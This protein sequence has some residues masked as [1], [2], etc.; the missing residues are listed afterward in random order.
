MSDSLGYS[1][2]PGRGPWTRLVP[3]GAFLLVTAVC[4]LLNTTEMTIHWPLSSKK[5][6]PKGGPLFPSTRLLRSTESRDVLLT[7]ARE[8]LLYWWHIQH[9]QR[10]RHAPSDPA[11]RPLEPCPFSAPLPAPPPQPEQLEEMYD[12]VK[13]AVEIMEAMGFSNLTTCGERYPKLAPENPADVAS[14]TDKIQSLLASVDIPA[15]NS[16]ELIR[17]KF[18]YSATFRPPTPENQQ[19]DPS[20]TG[21]QL[22]SDPEFCSRLLQ[23][24]RDIVS[25]R[26]PPLLTVF[27][28]IPDPIEDPAKV[29]R[30][31]LA[32]N[33]DMFKPFVQPVLVSDRRMVMAIANTIQ[34]PC[35]PVTKLGPDNVP[36]FQTSALSV[37]DRFNS[38]FYGYVRGVSV[39]DASLLETLIATKDKFVNPLFRSGHSRQPEVMVFG[40]A[41]FKEDLTFRSNY[42]GVGT[43]AESRASNDWP[44]G[45]SS[46]TYVFHTKQ[47]FT[48][49]PPLTIDDKD[50]VPVLV[51]RAALLGNQVIDASN[52]IL[53]VYNI[54][55]GNT[56][57]WDRIPLPATPR[58]D[59]YNQVTGTKYLEALREKLS[60]R[61]PLLARFGNNGKILFSET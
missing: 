21:E 7:Q 53:T 22:V 42:S 6:D 9:T 14:A 31:Y 40:S 19:K 52:T 34:W 30:R 2:R 45:K 54:H 8:A 61:K 51:E 56:N 25:G 24:Y 5:P 16:E 58:I 33:L 47:S 55:L 32:L 41:L 46:M 39:F 12:S 11:T 26:E 29:S 48:D 10:A 23:L 43:M 1:L 28:W 49:L 50:L 37:M 60:P 38:T 18:C 44:D 57:E 20:S 15:S 17:K 13:Q 59:N 4:M 3:P 35:L 27:T 36:V